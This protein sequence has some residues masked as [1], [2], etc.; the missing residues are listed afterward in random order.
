[1]KARILFCAVLEVI[2]VLLMG[3][4]ILVKNAIGNMANPAGLD[5]GLALIGEASLPDD[6]KGKITVFV[7]NHC[8]PPSGICCVYSDRFRFVYFSSIALIAP[9]Q[10][11]LTTRL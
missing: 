9:R 5:A 7:C 6:Y 11:I 1:M 4:F 2:D 3:V 10:C 8:I